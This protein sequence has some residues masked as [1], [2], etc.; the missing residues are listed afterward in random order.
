LKARRLEAIQ[1]INLV[2]AVAG[3]E[4]EAPKEEIIRFEDVEIYASP[5]GC[6]LGTKIYPPGFVAKGKAFIFGGKV[7]IDCLLGSTGM[8]FKGEVEGFSLGPFVVTGD[9]QVDGTR[10]ESALLEFEI[11]KER[12]HFEVSVF[13]P[14]EVLPEPQREF[15]LELSW[16][17]LLKFQ[18]DGKL[19][20]DPADAKKG[21]IGK[22]ENAD[23]ELHVVMEQRILTA[24][25]EAMREW[26]KSVPASVHEGI[27][28]E[29]RR[30]K[31]G[32]RSQ[33]RRGQTCP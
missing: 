12:Q 22:L 23:F 3:F 25:A 10:G 33:N 7:E 14:A 28:A 32:V 24:I 11:A 2:N 26:F 29:S 4:I 16:S 9:K 20:K 5:L 13:V 6:L 8:R 21:T 18:V 19:I 1:V 30:G 17:N 15:N 31:E 27:K